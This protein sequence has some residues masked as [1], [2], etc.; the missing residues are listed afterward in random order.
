MGMQPQ[1]GWVCSPKQDGYAARAG[2][3][4]A[5]RAKTVDSRPMQSLIVTCPDCAEELE[6][7]HSD[8]LEFAVGDI[9]GCNACGAELEV[10]SLDPPEFEPLVY[11][12]EC[13][14]CGSF[15]ALSE[16]DLQAHSV[17]C[18]DCQF[19]FALEDS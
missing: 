9:L 6:I 11:S 1:A 8:W 18:P 10:L 14:K 5:A 2:W 13:P 17:T 15:F 3:V 7:L 16:P 12:T 4:H 19:S